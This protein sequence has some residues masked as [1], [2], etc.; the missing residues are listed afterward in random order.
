[1]LVKRIRIK[2]NKK[3]SFVP[4]KMQVFCG[5][6]DNAGLFWRRYLRY[7]VKGKRN[8]PNY[9]YYSTYS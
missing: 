8:E 2:D 4:N 1:M 7:S 6:Q 3:L 5:T 9:K